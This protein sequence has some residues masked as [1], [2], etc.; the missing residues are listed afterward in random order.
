M[1][2]ETTV[3]ANSDGYMQYDAV[4]LINTVLDPSSQRNIAG[5]LIRAVHCL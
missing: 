2:S 1:R 5:I 4:F 3:P